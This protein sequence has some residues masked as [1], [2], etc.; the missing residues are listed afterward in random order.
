MVVDA[1]TCR[2]LAP[3]MLGS[4]RLTRQIKV[5]A[6]LHVGAD[7]APGRYTGSFTTLIEYE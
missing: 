3:R 5:G 4:D 1:F 2:V 7:Q 6:T